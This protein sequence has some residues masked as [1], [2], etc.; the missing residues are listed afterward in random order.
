MA[1]LFTES[2]QVFAQIWNMVLIIIKLDGQHVLVP[3]DEW[4]TS[5]TQNNINNN[6]IINRI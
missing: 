6:I 4:E 1:V 3:S 5:G 2:A